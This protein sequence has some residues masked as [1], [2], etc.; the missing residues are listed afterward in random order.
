MSICSGFKRVLVN[1]QLQ[2]NSFMALR[3]SS[4]SSEV[5]TLVARCTRKI[6]ESVSPTQIKVTSSNDDPNGS[7]VSYYIVYF[8]QYICTSHLTSLSFI[9]DSNPLCC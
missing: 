7:H 3:E 8:L 4:S 9:V 6:S 5:E 2:R 1:K